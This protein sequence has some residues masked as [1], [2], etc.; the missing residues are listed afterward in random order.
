[1]LLLYAEHGTAIMMLVLVE[2]PTVPNIG[3]PGPKTHNQCVLLVS[4]RIHWVRCFFG[5]QKESLYDTTQDVPAKREYVGPT[6][7][8]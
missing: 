7:C 8:Q 4:P 2:V 5:T 1:M 6:N 3:E